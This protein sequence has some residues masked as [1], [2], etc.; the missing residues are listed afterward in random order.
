MKPHSS[1]RKPRE[2]AAE[3]APSDDWT[4]RNPV[5]ARIWPEVTHALSPA[6]GFGKAQCPVCGASDTRQKV[7]T[8][9]L[10]ILR[11]TGS[12]SPGGVVPFWLQFKDELCFSCHA[13]LDG[14]TKKKPAALKLLEEAVRLDPKNEA[15]KKNLQALRKMEL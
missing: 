12:F 8:S 11:T 10:A 5:A 15:A 14:L 4:S 13:E 3:D 7:V 9:I 6:A 2:Q 1:E